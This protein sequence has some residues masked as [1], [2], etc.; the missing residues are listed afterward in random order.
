MSDR[1]I[2][3]RIL[4]EIAELSES[5]ALNEE[6]MNEALDAVR[7]RYAPTIQEYSCIIKEKEKTLVKLMKEDRAAIFEGEDT[8]ELVHGLLLHGED[9]KVKIPRDAVAALERLE[10]EDGLKRSVSINRE[11]IE[12][13]PEERLFAIGAERK[14]KETFDYELTG[15]GSGREA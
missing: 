11:V 14:L 2:A 4:A 12:K 6:I 8:V 13:W 1:K 3:D 7:Q 10:W 15:Q 5:L 9:L